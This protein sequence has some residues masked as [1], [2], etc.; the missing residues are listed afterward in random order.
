MRKTNELSNLF[1]DLPQI[2]SCIRIIITWR[3]WTIVKTPGFCHLEAAFYSLIDKI[4]PVRISPGLP[5]LQVAKRFVH[6]Q[7]PPNINMH[8]P[9]HPNLLNERVTVIATLRLWVGSSSQTLVCKSV[10]HLWTLHWHSQAL[11][12]ILRLSIIS[13]EQC[14]LWLGTFTIR[15]TRHCMTFLP[16]LNSPIFVTLF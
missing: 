15:M 7:T 6:S 1:D 10:E 8:H 12:K 5:N 11:T 3:Y 13:W 9:R 14:W 4:L 16:L 2:L